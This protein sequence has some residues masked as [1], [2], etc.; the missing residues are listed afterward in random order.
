MSAANQILFED[1]SE[2]PDLLRSLA[3]Y[4]F[5]FPTFEDTGK[6]KSLLLLLSRSSQFIVCYRLFIE[7]CDYMCSDIVLGTFEGLH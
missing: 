7:D 5:S 6:T 3:E 2:V 1:R 4:P